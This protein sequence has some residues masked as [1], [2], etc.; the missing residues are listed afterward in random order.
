MHKKLGEKVFYF[1]IH[2][3]FLDNRRRCMRGIDAKKEIY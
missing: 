3:K 1:I 2:L